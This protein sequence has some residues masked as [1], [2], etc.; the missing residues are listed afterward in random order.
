MARVGI[1]EAP[2]AVQEA[3]DLA[4]GKSARKR[5]LAPGGILTSRFMARH[6]VV[7]QIGSNV[8]VHA[9][10]LPCH[11]DYGLER[12]NR[13]AADVLFAYLKKQGHKRGSMLDAN[14]G[15]CSYQYE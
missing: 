11:V 13:Y 1:C 14:G 4:A 3:W 5:A 8:F 12:I 10:L 6:P 15:K 9:G 7:L 2:Y